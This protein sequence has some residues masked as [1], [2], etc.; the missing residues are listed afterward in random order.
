[1]EYCK[2]RLGQIWASVHAGL[3]IYGDRQSKTFILLISYWLVIA[4]LDHSIG[5]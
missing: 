3:V 2:I 5:V 1:M 4:S